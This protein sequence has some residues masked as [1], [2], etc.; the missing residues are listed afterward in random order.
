[1]FAQSQQE[2]LILHQLGKILHWV[3]NTEVCN[4]SSATRR[5][6]QLHLHG[7][8]LVG[9]QC[10]SLVEAVKQNYYVLHWPTRMQSSPSPS[11]TCS[12]L[13]LVAALQLQKAFFPPLRV[14][15]LPVIFLGLHAKSS[16]QFPI[17]FCVYYHP[18]PG[19]HSSHY[20]SNIIRNKLHQMVVHVSTTYDMF[21]HISVT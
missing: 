11:L 5:T 4:Q 16:E 7:T 14:V 9:Q 19:T 6:C 2:N 21:T 15:Y 10:L 17:L 18:S 13:R 8:V 12:H 3:N 1:M 20:H